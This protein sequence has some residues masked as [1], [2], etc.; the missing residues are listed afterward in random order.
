MGLPLPP[1][2]GYVHHQVVDGDVEV[3]AELAENVGVQEPEFAATAAV[4]GSG[5]YVQ[6]LANSG[7]GYAPFRQFFCQFELKLAVVHVDTPLCDFSARLAAFPA[8]SPAGKA[9]LCLCF[10]KFF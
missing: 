9:Y 5:R 1:L 3:G 2:R 10:I 6:V 4:K 7:F 8:G